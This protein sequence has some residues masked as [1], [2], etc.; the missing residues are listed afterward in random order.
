M[1]GWETLGPNEHSGNTPKAFMFVL[2]CSN[3]NKPRCSSPD[4]VLTIGVCS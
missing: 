1:Q 2:H 3:E 4:S